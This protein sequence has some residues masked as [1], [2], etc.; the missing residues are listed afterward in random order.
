MADEQPQT[1]TEDEWNALGLKLFGTETSAWRFKC[2]RCSNVMSI[3]K[4]LA[5]SAEQL[6][7]LRS[8]EWA[9]ESECIGRYIDLGCNWAAYGLFSGPFF[10]VRADGRKTPTF[11][12]DIQ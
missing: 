2:P 4:A 10:V 12:F 7:R 8:G 6:A 9:I 5:L 11:G 3:E 1:M